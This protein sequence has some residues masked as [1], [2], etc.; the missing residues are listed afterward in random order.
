MYYFPL[1]S[2]LIEPITNGNTAP[3]YPPLISVGMSFGLLS[4]N[5]EHQDTAGIG[6][7]NISS[8]FLKINYED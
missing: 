1:K 4:L 3:S 7:I 8:F 5:G 6:I 2:T